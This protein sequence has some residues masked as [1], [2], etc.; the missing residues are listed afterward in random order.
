M[1]EERTVM[2]ERDYVGGEIWMVVNC[3]HCDAEGR[4]ART[5]GDDRPFEVACTNCGRMFRIEDS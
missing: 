4:Y 2:G 1:D 3:P 5:R